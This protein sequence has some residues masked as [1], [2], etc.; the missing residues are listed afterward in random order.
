MTPDLGHDTGS[1]AGATLREGSAVGAEFCPGHDPRLRSKFLVR[2][3]DGDERA[4]AEF[5]NDWSKPSGNV[6]V[7]GT[8][9]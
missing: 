9:A 6:G 7:R 1:T 5:L 3:E 8:R 4:V 2:S